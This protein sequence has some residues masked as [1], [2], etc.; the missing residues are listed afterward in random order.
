[1]A[2]MDWRHCLCV[3]LSCIDDVV[4]I[5][6]DW[7]CS[8][9]DVELTEKNLVLLLCTSSDTK[10]WKELLTGSTNLV[11]LGISAF[12]TVGQWATSAHHV[13]NTPSL[14]RSCKKYS[15]PFPALETQHRALCLALHTHQCS[16]VR[17]NSV[18][19]PFHFA[20]HLHCNQ[21]HT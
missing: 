6:I 10:I 2:S 20:S 19:T 12:F 17:L 9:C 18:F 4:A 11:K 16:R 13:K 3:A 1:M 15:Q 7:N 8:H 21:S 14:Q 5:Q